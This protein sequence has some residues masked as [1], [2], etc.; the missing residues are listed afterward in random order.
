[1]KQSYPDACIFGFTLTNT[2]PYWIIG[3]VRSPRCLVVVIITVL[4]GILL[5]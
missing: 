3:L 1:V 4:L 5:G 2:L